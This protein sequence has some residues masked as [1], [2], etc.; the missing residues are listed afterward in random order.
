MSVSSSFIRSVDS[1]L[2]RVLLVSSMLDYVTLCRTS[3]ESVSQIAVTC[4]RQLEPKDTICDAPNERAWDI[5]S[6]EPTTPIEDLH[7]KAYGNLYD[8]FL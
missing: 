7:E 8:P 4:G 5:V 2:I 6:D 1:S 3:P